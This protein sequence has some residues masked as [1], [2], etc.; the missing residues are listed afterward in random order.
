MLIFLVSALRIIF[1]LSDEKITLIPGFEVPYKDAHIL[2]IGVDHFV[3]NGPNT[4]NE[5]LL[6]KK[7]AQLAIWA[8]PHKNKYLLYDA[9]KAVI[10]GIEVWN[11]QYDGKL[12]PRMK[13]L[14][15]LLG[16]RERGQKSIAFAGL[17]FHRKEHAGGPSIIVECPNNQHDI[18]ETI[19]KG[20]FVLKNKQVTIR[21]NGTILK[22]I[23]PLMKFQ[24]AY[25]ILVISF[26]K[27]V[28][29]ITASLRIPI[30]QKLRHNIR[31]RL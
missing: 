23:L 27:K 12:A 2:M 26:F 17:D 16:L 3:K 1:D 8:H 22:G 11:S 7:H 15:S 10:D 13:V 24:S 5:L 19:K 18:L 20:D 30:P 29:K 28:S 14:S 4:A 25:R 21:S 31:K 6:W 9:I